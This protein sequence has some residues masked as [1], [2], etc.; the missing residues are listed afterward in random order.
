MG[1]LPAA[2]EPVFRQLIVG[3]IPQPSAVPP[4][5]YPMEELEQVVFEITQDYPFQQFEFLPGEIGLQLT[6]TPSDVVVVQPGLH[7]VQTP[8]ELTPERA[9]E[10]AA[11]IIDR[12]SKRLKT[13]DYLA[14]GVKVVAHIPLPGADPDGKR[15]VSEKLMHAEELARVLGPDFFGGGV[16]YHS[17]SDD[18]ELEEVLL[19][20]PFVADNSLV[21][22]DFNVHHQ[23]RFSGL[24]QLG[25][26]ID[27]CFSFVSGPA[28]RIL[29][30][31]AR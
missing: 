30:E 16:K 2:L 18:A 7:Q 3:L 29:E 5:P 12:I 22:V 13:A 8:V 26:W 21:F 9:R 6:N 31:H 25:T 17:I 15:F 19:L 28:M 4:A 10:K 24:D 1:T 23:R 11:T 27:N 14:Y 20:E